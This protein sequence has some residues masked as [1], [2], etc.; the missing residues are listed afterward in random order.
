MEYLEG[1]TLKQELSEK[2]LTLAQVLDLS[3][4]IADGL[5]AAHQKG[6]VHRDIKPMNLFVTTRG[7]VKILDFGLAKLTPF[8]RNFEA[9][10]RESDSTVMAEGQLTSPGT[11]LGTP[12]RTRHRNRQGA[13]S[14]M[15]GQIYFRLSGAVM[16]WLRVNSRS[17]A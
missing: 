8:L 17:A 6:I 15:R 10:K 5:E 13:K 1:K 11:A 4:Q 3:I 16:K 9:E 12:W 14:S 7:H 2:A